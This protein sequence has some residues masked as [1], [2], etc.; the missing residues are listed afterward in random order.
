MV[1]TTLKGA[2]WK[3]YFLVRQ[4]THAPVMAIA[5]FLRCCHLTTWL[6]CGVYLT[7]IVL[8]VVDDLLCFPTMTNMHA[9]LIDGQHDVTPFLRC[10]TSSIPPPG[11]TLRVFSLKVARWVRFE[12]WSNETKT[13]IFAT[14][15]RLPVESHYMVCLAA[16]DN[17]E[18]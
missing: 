18:K 6:M 15:L 2:G 11:S 5:K 3:K 7:W 8:L 16:Y 13:I 10:H 12:P 1:Q 9:I 17:C 14:N 4:L